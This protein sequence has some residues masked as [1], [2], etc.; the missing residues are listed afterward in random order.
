MQGRLPPQADD[1]LCKGE[2]PRRRGASEHQG[3]EEEQE[4]RE[5][6]IRRRVGRVLPPARIQDAHARRRTSEGSDLL[7]FQPDLLGLRL[8]EQGG[9]GPLRPGVG[10]PRLRDAPRPRRERSCE[11]FN[12]GPCDEAG[13]R[14]T[15]RARD[16]VGRTG[17]LQS[18]WNLGIQASGD[19][20]RRSGFHAAV[21]RSMNQESRHWL[22][23]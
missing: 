20:V 15:Y 5:I 22:K 2:Q 10:L 3:H 9:Q 17:I 14:L 23:A 18:L 11:H 16:T 1:A 7:P 6:H 21:L 13:S 12:Q 4:A 19:C 8:P